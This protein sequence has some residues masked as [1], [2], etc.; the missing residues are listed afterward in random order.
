MTQS[1][2]SVL[3]IHHLITFMYSTFV[4][5]LCSSDIGINRELDQHNVII[6]GCGKWTLDIKWVTLSWSKRWYNIFRRTYNKWSSLNLKRLIKRSLYGWS[7]CLY[8]ITNTLDLESGDS[9]SSYL[10]SFCIWLVRFPNLRNQTL[11]FTKCRI[12]LH[13]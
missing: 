2:W 1:K 13:L 9:Q 7:L 4:W 8:F 6:M 10:R 11:V 5:E 3:Y 12:A